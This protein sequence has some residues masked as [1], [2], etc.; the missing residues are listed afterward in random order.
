MS[1]VTLDPKVQLSILQQLQSR[2][3]GMSTS[4]IAKLT[5]QLS[6]EQRTQLINNILGTGEIEMLSKA[7]GTEVI[8][9]YQKSAL[10]SDAPQEERLVSY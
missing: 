1:D 10:S 2:K 6:N 3:D 5:P 7:G 9:K 4:E 8:L